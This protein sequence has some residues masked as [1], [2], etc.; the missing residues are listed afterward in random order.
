MFCMMCLLL[1]LLVTSLQSAEYFCIAGF[2]VYAW[3]AIGFRFV[4]HHVMDA[5]HD[6]GETLKA[7]TGD[8]QGLFRQA[9]DVIEWYWSFPGAPKRL[10][11]FRR[12]FALIVIFALAAVAAIVAERRGVA[13]LAD[14]GLAV[15]TTAIVLTEIE[16]FRWRNIRTSKLHSIQE[17][18][19]ELAWLGAHPT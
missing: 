5:V 4:R 2:A 17:G 11:Q 10:G 1:T 3:H 12:L 7:T 19:R 14:Y 9:L 6:A 13:I 16:I 15:G 18:L 8:K